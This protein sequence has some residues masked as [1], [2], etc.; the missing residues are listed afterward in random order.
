MNIL[1]LLALF[2]A[3]EATAH[4]RTIQPNYISTNYTLFK[5]AASPYLNICFKKM[6]KS[7]APPVLLLSIIKNFKIDLT[8]GT[9][10]LDSLRTVKF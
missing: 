5:K 1:G 7:C 4:P 6:K 3:A 10:R 9:S 2:W 8:S